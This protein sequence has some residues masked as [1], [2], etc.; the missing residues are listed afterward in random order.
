MPDVYV[1]GKALGGG[2]LALSAIAADDEILGVFGPGSHGSTFGGNPLACAVGRAVLELLRTGEPQ[3]NAA[4]MGAALRAELDAAAPPALQRDPL[5]RPVVRPRPRSRRA[6][7]ARRVRA[8]AAARRAREGHARAHD[9]ARAAADDRRRG[10]RL[11]ARGAARGARREPAAAPRRNCR[12]AAAAP[13]ILC[14][15]DELD[16]HIVAELLEDGRLS[17]AELGERVNLSSPAVK[18]RVD[19]LRA[20]GVITGF[21]ALVDPGALGQNTEAFVEVHC[22]ANMS[23]SALRETLA[24][25]PEVVAAYTVSGD[26][27]ALVHVRATDVAH[28]E[29]TV[30]RI[31][32]NPEIARTKTIIVLS[33]LIARDG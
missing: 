21:T 7:C 2:I 30:E 8:A 32:A 27:D 26:A 22:A 20:T 14:R 29:A 3:A 1:L 15:I 23:P 24:H 11:A 19:R 18:R 17:L 5:A 12:A 6:R 4:R 13:G 33:R 16:R 28:L 10:G 9:P 25:E 31:R